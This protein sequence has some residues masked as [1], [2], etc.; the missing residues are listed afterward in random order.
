MHAAFRAADEMVAFLLSKGASPD[1]MDKVAQTALVFAIQSSCPSTIDLLAPVTQKG[2]E[3]ALRA[4][5]IW[6][7][8]LTPAVKELLKRASSDKDAFISGVETATEMGATSMLKILTNGW[9]RNTLHSSDEDYLLQLALKSDNAE[10][11]QVVLAFV[12]DVSSENL[13]LALTRGRADVVNLFGL[14]EDE[15][16]TEAAKKRLKAAIVN[17]TASIENR[18]PKSVEFPYDDEMTKLRPLLSQSTV[19][20]EDLLRALHVPPVH[21]E[22]ECPGDCRQKEDCDRLR[23]VYFLVRLLVA[24]MGEIN[25]VF[26]LGANRHPSIIGSM[27]EHTRVF[28]NNELDVHISLNK[29]LRNKFDF[30]QANQQLKANDNLVEGDHIKK[31]VSDQGI[32]DCKKY[33]FDF[34]ECLEDALTKVDISQGFKIGD[35]HH[36]FTMEP[37]TTSY[38]PC[39]R[40]MLT[41]ETGRPQARRCRHRPDC[42]PHR[43]GMAECLNGCK[44]RCESFSHERTCNCQEY[45]SPSLTIT[46]IGVA[47]HVKFALKD[48]SYSYVDCDINIPTIPTSTRY[49]GSINDVRKYLMRVQPVGWLEELSK[50]ENMSSAVNSFHLIGADSWQVKMRMINRDTVLPRQVIRPNVPI[51]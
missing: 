41:T 37:P 11:V 51:P 31:Y 42:E 3:S 44:D 34:M 47:L 32:F 28:F 45:T 50:L 8:E 46:K 36:K 39:L 19:R 33:T 13:A 38:E 9:N 12:S 30:D 1:L 29:V 4:L 25:P 10:T 49:D 24:K 20:Y 22:E 35:K 27:R 16:S 40:C 26:R 23:Q 18:L 2:L 15:R 14:G 43:D 21:A 48:G 7:T 6:K 5:A 17:K